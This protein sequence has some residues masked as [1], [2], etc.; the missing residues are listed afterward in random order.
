MNIQPQELIDLLN[1]LRSRATEF[2]KAGRTF[3]SEGIRYAADSLQEL[4]IANDIIEDDNDD[5]IDPVA[6]AEYEYG[7]EDNRW[8]GS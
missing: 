1:S 7:N 4:L 8:N 2:G 6:M 3:Y 5:E